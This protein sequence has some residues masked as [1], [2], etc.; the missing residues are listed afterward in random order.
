MVKVDLSKIRAWLGAVGPSL[1]ICVSTFQ[2]CEF[3]HGVQLKEVEAED[4]FGEFSFSRCV[5]C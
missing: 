4:G 5:C 1:E 2:I 3:Y